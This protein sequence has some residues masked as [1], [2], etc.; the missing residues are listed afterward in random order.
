MAG[1]AWSVTK[2]PRFST[3]LQ[4]GVSGRELRALDQGTPT[5]DFTLTFDLLRDQNDTRAAVGLGDGFD[6]L[7]QLMGFWLSRQGSF[8]TF[9]FE[10]PT[11]NVTTGETIGAG[12]GSLTTYQLVR[13]IGGYG[14]FEPI[15]APNLTVGVPFVIYLDGVL[16]PGA[17]NYSVD[18]D[19]G[20][21]TFTGPPAN[22]VIVTVDFSYYFRCRFTDD[23]AE[24]ENFMY[25]LWQMKQLKFQS[26]LL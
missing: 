5:W 9:L 17:G 11:D 2:A 24:F 13:T 12:T 22:G 19:T 14:F 21:V 8:N 23:S 15:T 3:R 1:L 4:K 18:G 20:I 7:R 26:V 25:Q 10:D 16:L 6:E